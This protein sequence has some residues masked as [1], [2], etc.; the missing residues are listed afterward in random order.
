MTVDGGQNWTSVC[1]LR[2]GDEVINFA[3]RNGRLWALG[4]NQNGNGWFVEK[5][6]P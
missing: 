1:S 5:Y 6:N 2:T 4:N 3:T